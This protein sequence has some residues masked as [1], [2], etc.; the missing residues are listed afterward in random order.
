MGSGGGKREFTVVRN[1]L[2]A[3]E[4]HLQ[5]PE[6][7]SFLSTDEG[8]SIKTGEK[9]S[10]K[11]KAEN[12]YN[13]SKRV[14]SKE[15][16]SSWQDEDYLQ[17]R[18]DELDGLPREFQE[19][20]QEL[21]GCEVKFVTQKKLFKTDLNP[22]HARLSIPPAK[23]ANRF[24]TPTE[25]SSLNERRGKHKRLS[26]MPVMVLDPSLREYNMCFKKWEMT[27][28]YVYNLTMGWNQIVGDNHLKLGDTLHL[29]S[30]RLSSQLCFAL[31]KG[32]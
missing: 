7:F 2:A 22:Q 19:K 30:F 9:I 24:L 12:N 17:K 5:R 11:R 13:P 1:F 27:K 4:K 26:G 25:E 29:W 31:V 8:L 3:K 10:L 23:I 15:G 16:A 14:K 21:N 18:I 6:C 32:S 28:S 20:I